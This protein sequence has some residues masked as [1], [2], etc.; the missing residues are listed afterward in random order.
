MEMIDGF[1]IV[2]FD[3]SLISPTGFQDMIDR[4][5]L[6]Q[7]A[8][9]VKDKGD[10]IYVMRVVDEYQPLVKNAKYVLF[11]KKGLAGSP[12]YY[13]FAAYYGKVN[14]DNRDK[15]ENRLDEIYDTREIRRQ[16]KERYREE[17]SD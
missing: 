4:S 3:G 9:I 16:A 17:V 6:G 15:S 1:P 5:D 11:L 8:A 13:P 10:S 12:A 2:M 14:L 7:E